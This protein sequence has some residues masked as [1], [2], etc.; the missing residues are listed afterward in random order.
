MA[1]TDVPYKP[2]V[3]KDDPQYAVEGYATDTQWI[4]WVRGKAQSL[5]GYTVAPNDGS[6]FSGIA[7]GLFSWA[8]TA[9]NIYAA[10]GTSTKLMVYADGTLYNVTP[11]RC[12]G[13]L[14]G[15]G[16]IATSTG[17]G[18]V[19][20]TCTNH[21]AATGDT[22]VI[23]GDTT[24]N[25]V[26]L[27]GGTGTFANNPFLVLAGTNRVLCTMSSHSMS[28][29]DEIFIS[30]ASAIN[31]V[32]LSGVYLTS[33]TDASNFYVYSN[34]RPTATGQGGGTPTYAI[35]KP[36][37]VTSV[38]TVDT[39]QVL[40]KTTANATGTGGGFGI[41]YR[42]EMKSGLNNS[43]GAAGGFG[44]GDYG[45]GLYGLNT[46]VAPDTINTRTWA[47]D[48]NGSQ[49]IATP[50]GGAIYT[51]TQNWSQ[52]AAR[53]DTAPQRNS[54]TTFT[55][56]RFIM[57]C[58]T[59]QLGALSALTTSSPVNTVSGSPIVTLT[60]PADGWVVGDE[61]GLQGVTAVGGVN[62]IN[63][64]IVTAAPSATTIQFAMSG[65]S[66]VTGSGGGNLGFYRR[67]TYVPMRIR[68]SDGGLNGDITQWI[69]S[70]TNLAGGFTA[71]IGSIMVAFRKSRSGIFGWSDYAM[72]FIRYTGQQDNPYTIDML[73]QGCGLAGPQ[74]AI[75]QD[76]TAYW[77]TKTLLPYLYN[78]GAP[79][80]LPSP[81]KQFFAANLA[82]DQNYKI[83][84]VYDSLYPALVWYY[85]SI[86]GAITGYEND[87]YIRLDL[88]E[89]SADA[90]AGWSVGM[91]SFTAAMDRGLI[92]YPMTTTA[93][94]QLFFMENSDAA[95]GATLSRYVTWGPIDIGD[96]DKVLN[97]RRWVVNANQSG[98]LNLTMNVARWPNGATTVKGPY[99]IPVGT[100]KTDVRAQGRQMTATLQSN[101]YF[102]LGKSRID[103][104]GGGYR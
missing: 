104:T 83:Y 34:T 87:S 57:T 36:Y 3:I 22:V 21:Q 13:V 65:P 72:Y 10:I 27:G 2:G 89:A 82:S 5:G 52:R 48:N 4:R 8:D 23:R 44:S 46:V 90:N 14:T 73:G 60:V 54:Y 20:I 56:E 59:T 62:I 69:P 63:N 47:L 93:S 98:T 17:S 30:G 35:G 77:I 12:N 97:V 94:G 32:T 88:P 61:I 103:I 31:G 96:G 80:P 66:N 95:N 67:N 79:R 101:S 24:F 99:S 50:L 42:F 81:I 49:L 7:R 39:F 71:T 85:P 18:N 58:G 28:S 29:G 25:N 15:S 91:A 53:I 74:A 26:R 43:Q 51:W 68:N 33:V 76:G 40:S 16:P 75:E 84:G 38:P 55:N 41:V 45:S 11:E 102:R 78:G 19:T 1:L 64:Y 37:V 9:G 86:A 70:A 100:E 92:N 6:T